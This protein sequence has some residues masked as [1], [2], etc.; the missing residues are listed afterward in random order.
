M[1]SHRL[2][3]NGDKITIHDLELFVG[4]DSSIDSDEDTKMKKYT[5]AKIAQVVERTRAYM[6]KGQNPKLILGHNPDDDDGSVRPSIG[7]IVSIMAVDINGVPGI[8]GDVEVSANVFDTTIATNAFP[9]RSAEIWSD[10]YLSEVALLGSQT[11][12]RPIPD[13]KFGRPVPSGTTREVF[14][15]ALP[16][17]QFAA[18]ASMFDPGPTNVF[19]PSGATKI[20][21]DHDQMKAKL[22]AM[23]EEN[24]QLKAKM[25]LMEHDGN[26]HED[27]ENYM[28]DD[29]K[30][31]HA[32]RGSKSKSS[33]RVIEM[34]RDEFRRQLELQKVQT[35]D[36][37]ADWLSERYNRV[38]DEMEMTGYRVPDKPGLIRKI[39][40][41]ADPAVSLDEAKKA[42]DTEL[43]F[44]KSFMSKSPTNMRIDQTGA[45]TSVPGSEVEKFEREEAAADRARDRC[46]LE[47]TADPTKFQAYYAEELK[48]G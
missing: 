13:T 14:S 40:A 34:E 24:D 30:G 11:P 19:I 38:V 18:T 46:V 10:G 44:I 12:A 3:R 43:A 16:V 35:D 20:M 36:L 26:M 41:A 9:R 2:T 32:R 29:C 15:R 33:V 6:A 45:R 31:K 42:C 4:F 39:I 5:A 22:K 23:E 48:T 37:R 47:K 8:V 7:D 17:V 1:A 28:D 27:D 21:D 25:K